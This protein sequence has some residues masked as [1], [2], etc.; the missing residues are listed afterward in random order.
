MGRKE[1]SCPLDVVRATIR[2]AGTIGGR[3]TREIHLRCKGIIP[4]AV[5]DQI[6][7]LDKRELANMSR[8]PLGAKQVS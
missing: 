1:C 2:L 8:K 4:Q 6:E 7:E 3:K 5:I